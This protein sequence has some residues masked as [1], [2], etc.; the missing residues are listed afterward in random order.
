[1]EVDLDHRL[2]HK[3]TIVFQ[4]EGLHRSPMGGLYFS[5][6]FTFHTSDFKQNSETCHMPKFSDDNASVGCIRDGQ[7]EYRGLVEYFVAWC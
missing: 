6:L 4:A 5:F 7:G 3:Q 1:M 2:P